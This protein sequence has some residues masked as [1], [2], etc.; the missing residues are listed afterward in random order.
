M[1][2]FEQLANDLQ[3]TPIVDIKDNLISAVKSRLASYTHGELDEWDDLINRLPALKTDAI[4]LKSGVSVGSS[5]SIEK[6]LSSNQKQAFIDDLKIL[7]PWRKGPFNLFGIHID[8]E[9]RSDW[10][11]ERLLPHIS[12]LSNRTVLDVGCGNGYHCWR[13]L[14]EDA[15]FVLGIDPSQKFL[16]Q[17]S[18]IKKYVG[19]APVHL[20][21]IGIEDMPNEMGKK[22]FDTVFSMGVLYH[23]KS[24][25]DHLLELK[26]MLG[27]K[28]ELI[29]ETLVIDGDENQVL[30]PKGR[31]A[32]MRNV[33]FI[34]SVKALELWLLKCGFTN[35]RTVDINQTS[36]DEQ[37]ATGWMHFHSLANYLDPTDKTLTVE[38]YP[39]PKRAILVANNQ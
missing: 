10:K 8:T 22:G 35:I 5:D 15:K 23:R 30:V 20:L 27:K 11:W 9:W 24:P 34:P 25:I 36:L 37:R 16:A 2:D 32:Q 18:V 38:G 4:D 29:L 26:N 21:P 6:Q 12:S 31:Y 33:W 19:P 17:F 39:A 1:I 7:H 14:G 3:S 13:M 28:G